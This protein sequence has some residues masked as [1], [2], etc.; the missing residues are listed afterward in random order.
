MYKTLAF[1]VAL[2]SVV[3]WLKEYRGWFHAAVTDVF[4][5]IP[6]SSAQAVRANA[7]TVATAIPLA[8]LPNFIV[9]SSRLAVSLPG[10]GEPAR[11]RSPVGRKCGPPSHQVMRSLVSSAQRM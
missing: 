1:A 4:S 9:D 8:L 2:P 10:A 3:F 7:A 11:K 6:V 5:T